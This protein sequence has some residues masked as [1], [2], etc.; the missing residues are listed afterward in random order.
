MVHIHSEI[1]VSENPPTMNAKIFVN[2][3]KVLGGALDECPAVRTRRPIGIIGSFTTASTVR[4]VRAILSLSLYSNIRLRSGFIFLLLFLLFLFFFLCFASICLHLLWEDGASL[5][6]RCMYDMY[7]E[8]TPPST[9]RQLLLPERNR[10]RTWARYTWEYDGTKKL[11]AGNVSL[12]LIHSQ[13]WK[14]E[15]LRENCIPTGIIL[16]R[17]DIVIVMWQVTNR[18]SMNPLVVVTKTRTTFHS[19]NVNWVIVTEVHGLTR[20]GPKF[21]TR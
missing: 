21:V 5:F 10:V 9:I 13:R 17:R 15:K 20:P 2:R 11:I 6:W 1:G 19:M 7:A 12:S 16:E 18:N 3:C 8:N 4:S 14:I